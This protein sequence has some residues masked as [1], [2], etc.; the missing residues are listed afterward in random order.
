MNLFSKYP[1]IS[2]ILHHF[3]S[4]KTFVAMALI[5]SLGLLALILIAG[6]ILPG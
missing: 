2:Q 6:T 4:L 1:K 5:F 3:K